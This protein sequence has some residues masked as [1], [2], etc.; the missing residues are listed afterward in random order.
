MKKHLLPVFYE[1]VFTET[2]QR[3]C[4]HLD[5]LQKDAKRTTKN[6][7]PRRY[8]CKMI[9][10]VGTI[11]KLLPYIRFFVFTRLQA[12]PNWGIRKVKY[13]S[14]FFN[15]ISINKCFLTGNKAAAISA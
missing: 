15:E 13:F 9:G 12:V 5:T 8:L 10:R 7:L 2:K 4:N 11:N 14:S 1:A 3:E 6:F